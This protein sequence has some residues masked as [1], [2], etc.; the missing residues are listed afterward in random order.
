M[1]LVERVIDILSALIAIV[2][3]YISLPQSK[4]A[5]EK[6]KILKFADGK[7]HVFLFF[8][9][10]WLIINPI[11]K[12]YTHTNTATKQDIQDSQ[13]AVET[14]SEMILND[15]VAEL[16]KEKWSLESSWDLNDF[17]E[18]DQKIKMAL[19]VDQSMWYHNGGN[20]ASY[21]ELWSLNRRDNPL[22]QDVRD[23]ILHVNSVLQLAKAAVRRF[24]LCKLHTNFGPLGNICGEVETESDFDV[25][26]VVS[27]VPHFSY[28]TS[29]AKSVYLLHFLTLDMMRESG[30]SWEVVLDTL[31][32][33]FSGSD[34]RYKDN[35]LL[36]RYMAWES[37]R[38]H[39]CFA[40][41]K[42]LFDISKASAWW[43]QEGNRQKVLNALENGQKPPF[44]N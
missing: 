43:K 44:C 15:A 22:R 3:L 21:E 29:R 4:K 14:H 7:K 11:V 5:R 25:S 16:K 38:E 40:G 23:Q 32:A 35:N 26:N 31:Y 27:Q 19:L 20:Y 42:E 41:G 2:I 24:P 17:Q 39:T 30:V 13:E 34:E 28:W 1:E 18:V 6:Y 8:I 37:F 9:A 33:A 12:F 36:V 10:F